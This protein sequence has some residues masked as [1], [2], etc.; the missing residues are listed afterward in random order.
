MKT[1]SKGSSQDASICSIGTSVAVGVEVGSGVGVS[2]CL[3]SPSSTAAAVYVGS[4]SF[5]TVGVSAAI[6]SVSVSPV[7]ADAVLQA[8]NKRTPTN[9][10]IFQVKL[11][12]FITVSFGRITKIFSYQNQK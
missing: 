3:F 1:P 4:G 12:P 5:S 6:S 9:N 7:S 2:T 11:K 10:I 8:V